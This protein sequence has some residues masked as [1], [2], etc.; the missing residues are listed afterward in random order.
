MTAPSDSIQIAPPAVL[1]DWAARAVNL[2]DARLGAEALACS[3]DFFAPAARLLDPRPARFVPD[4][5]DDHGKWMDGWETRRK[6][7]AG[8]DWCIVKLGCAGAIRGFD[9]DT[10]F[11]TGN[12]PPAVSVEGCP[13]GGDPEGKDWRALTPTLALQGGRHHL[14]EAPGA[15]DALWSHLRVNIFPDGGLARLRV[16]GRPAAQVAEA[17][18]DGL[19]D[20][21]AARHGGR[22]LAWNDAHYGAAANLLLPGRGVNMGDGWE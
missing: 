3:D 19:V 21:A 1:P 4:K 10:S 5:Y 16:Y 15:G 6:R 14:I 2:A 7:I 12:Y 8:H 9:F 22:A 11:F 13:A 18:P 17:G 20:L